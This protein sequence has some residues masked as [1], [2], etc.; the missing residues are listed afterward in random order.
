MRDGFNVTVGLGEDVSEDSDCY[1]D[2]DLIKL[3]LVRRGGIRGFARSIIDTSRFLRASNYD[4]VVV[5]TPA[6]A[7][8]LRWAI[9]PYL[10]VKVIYTVHGFYFHEYMPLLKKV[11]HICSEFVLSFRTSQFIFVSQED[12]YFMKKL[13]F[14]RAANDFH[15][16]P[17]R[18][19]ASRFMFVESNR[20][21]VRSKLELGPDTVVF[22]MVCRINPEKGVGEFLR[23]ALDISRNHSNCYFL[24]VG[25]TVQEEVSIEFGK[26]LATSK[27]ALS[28][29]MHITGFTDDVGGFLS[30]IDC[31][32]LPSYREGYPVSYLEAL[33]SGCH[34]IVSNIRGCREITEVADDSVVVEPRS[35]ASLKNAML[36][37]L[38]SSR[39]RLSQRLAKSVDMAYK[40][41][42]RPG[43]SEQNIVIEKFIGKGPVDVN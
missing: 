7:F 9:F 12:F 29:R 32:C 43:L 1:K 17:N 22:G 31:F 5:H 42:S 34:C 38:L 13:L 15:F 33:V 27:I 36:S 6:A 2:I 8:L 21:K 24:I 39:P 35:V 16:V 14:F 11:V 26:L 28:D 19:D 3:P 40:F 10:K 30:A 25:D 37:F 20:R 18:V 23:A 4:V 41:G